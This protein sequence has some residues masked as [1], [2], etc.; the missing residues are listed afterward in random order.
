MFYD[1]KLDDKSYRE[2]EADAIFRIP[3]EYPEWTNHNPS[4]PGIMLVQL[5]SWLKEAQQYHL[6]RLSIQKRKK[7]LKLLGAKVRTMRPAEGA[8]CVEQGPGQDG[9]RLRLLK[10]TRF[11]AGDM[12]FETVESR[13]ISPARLIGAYMLQGNEFSR[14]HTIGSH[15]GKQMRLY[16]FGEKPEIGSQC[17]FVLDKKVSGSRPGEQEYAADIFFDIRTEYEVTRNPIGEDF[18]PLARLKWEYYSIEGWEETEP[19]YDHTYGFL[20]SGNIRFRMDKEMA[21]EESMGAFEL[22]VTLEENFYDVAPLIRNIYL[23]EIGVKQQYSFCDYEDFVLES[24]GHGETVLTLC[25][26]LMLAAYGETMLYLKKGDGWEPAEILKKEQEGT[27]EVRI[28]FSE[29]DW[30]EGTLICRLT[31]WEREFTDRRVVGMG[32]AFAN[33]EFDLNLSDILYDDFEIM[34]R[35]G[36]EGR[37]TVW[38]KAEDFDSCKPWEPAYLLDPEEGRLLFGNCENGRAPKG[39]IRLI[40]LRTCAGKSGNIKAGKIRECEQA[41]GLLVKQYKETRDGWDNETIDQCVSRFRRRLKEVSRGVTYADYEELVKKAPGLLILDSR[42]IGPSEWLRE[43]RAVPE[44]QVSIVVQTVS[45]DRKAVRLNE[46]YRQNLS[47]MLEKKKMLGTGIQILD[48]EYIGI[49]VYAEIVALPQF[50]DTEKQLKDAVKAYLDEK[51]WEIGRPVLCSTL[52]G[53]LDTLPCVEQVRT[54]SL[55]ARGKGCRCLANGDVDLP[56]NGLAYLEELDFA[57][58][59]SETEWSR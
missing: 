41:S 52:Y 54:L 10:G 47:R 49:S 55:N 33:Q 4:D 46:R 30:A 31:A 51:A 7:F 8:V 35:D 27:G 21:V 6:S 42:V 1:L 59:R 37:F 45:Y 29:P 50:Q 25:S 40:R 13:E 56:P 22:R 17:Y 16:P 20:Q 36:E 5:F 58:M 19:E 26:H 12:A 57:V 18:I 9:K 48:P 28:S 3:K 39:E 24:S 32:D 11:F 14:Y 53:I 44:N 15:L 38:H 23:N 2:I 34:V 43:G